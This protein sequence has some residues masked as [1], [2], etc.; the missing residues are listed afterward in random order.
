[1]KIAIEPGRYV[2]A[3]SGGVDSMVLLDLLRQQTAVR[4][5]VAHFDHGV[6]D[7]SAADRELVQKTAA[8]Y[9]LPFVF[10]VARLGKGA[11]EDTA[12]RARYAFLH[13]VRV[14]A[15]A[16]AI[17]TAHHQ[18][19]MLET[20]VLNVLRGTGR[21]GLSS[22]RSRDRMLRP[23]LHCT[24]AQIRYYAAQHHI[25]WREDSTNTDDT[26]LRNYVRQHILNKFSE[27]ERAQLLAI[28]EQAYQLNDQIDHL[29]ANQ[30]HLQPATRQMDRRWFISLPHGVAR[31]MLAGWLRAHG[32]DGF[33]AKTLE[34]LVIAA[35]TYAPGK[36]ADITSRHV[37]T[38]G[39]QNLALQLHDR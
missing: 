17:I 8:A 18:D 20:A 1:M 39:R 7:D 24:K 38:V 21:R 4:L 34:R 16:R 29:L 19:D 15:G 36:R 10:D 5:V 6:R 30:L 12:R 32:I 25:S 3:V 13:K 23:L 33:D 22:L 27:A 37:L 2:L 9:G 11:S 14:A 26:Y 28:V 31:E 35:K